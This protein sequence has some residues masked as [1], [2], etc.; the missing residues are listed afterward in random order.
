MPAF[1]RRARRIGGRRSAAAAGPTLTGGATD[2]SLGESMRHLAPAAE[3]VAI[4]VAVAVGYVLPSVLMLVFHEPV[5]IGFWLFFPV[6]VSLIR[7]F[8]RFAASR[9][10]RLGLL[11]VEAETMYLES[12]RSALLAI[13]GVPVACS[14]ASHALF[15]WSLTQPDDRSAM[16]RA[17][18]WLVAVDS[19]FVAVAVL[20]WV[21]VEA[22]WRTVAL[23]V[24]PTS[25]L[26]GP[27]AGICLGWVYRERVV[28][29]DFVVLGAAAD[30]RTQDPSAQERAAAATADEET[31]LIGSR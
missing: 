14:V 25:A 4:P 30:A 19:L 8:V 28:A 21:F 12:R 23:V 27:G 11:K 9:L 3:V 13:Y 31:P 16:T 29:P 26:L 20:Y 2:P 15:I 6:H 1:L 24:I 7:R 18:D 5:S 22:G 17:T 10:R